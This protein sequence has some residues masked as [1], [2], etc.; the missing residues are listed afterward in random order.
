MKRNCLFILAVGV[1]A[2]VAG[3]C[4]STGN[5]GNG[6]GKVKLGATEESVLAHEDVKKG[7]PV[8]FSAPIDRVREAG[9]RALTFVGCKIEEQQPFYLRGERPQKI[10]LFVGSGGETVEVFLLPQ[11]EGTQ[12]WVDT[13]L[14][15]VGIAGQQQW[16]EQTIGEM[17]RILN[18]PAP[19][20]STPAK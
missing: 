16:T 5:G 6:G 9:L 8:V 12:V 20:A 4:A 2:A 17:R 10:G 11:G 7:T 14:Q 15:F 18:Q 19:A 1:A 13:D 3:G